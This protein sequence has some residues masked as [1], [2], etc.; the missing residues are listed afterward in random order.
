MT[1]LELQQGL[2]WG[3]KR[4]TSLQVPGSIIQTPGKYKER[5]SLRSQGTEV[6][7]PRSVS[8]L[9]SPAPWIPVSVS[10]EP[11]DVGARNGNTS[12]DA[13]GVAPAPALKNTPSPGV[14]QRGE[15]SQSL[16]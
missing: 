2:L 1:V 10:G 6:I 8:K 9:G 4:F 15:D 5:I 7:C 3:S 14:P 13:F 12:Q 16:Y 11:W